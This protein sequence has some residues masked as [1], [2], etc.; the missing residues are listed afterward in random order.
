MFQSSGVLL[1]GH[2]GDL[3]MNLFL[4]WGPPF[5]TGDS[6]KMFHFR[7]KIAKHGRLD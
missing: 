4:L 2:I 3:V 6:P 5:M 7:P 1:A